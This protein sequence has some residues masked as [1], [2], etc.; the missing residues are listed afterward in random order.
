VFWL[1]EM[2]VTH[3]VMDC[4]L[5]TRQWQGGGRSVPVIVKFPG[6]GWCRKKRNGR[7]PVVHFLAVCVQAVW[8]RNVWGRFAV[9]YNDISGELAQQNEKEL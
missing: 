2:V 5:T 4:V 6:W 3:L 8:R 1:F 7:N 9:Q